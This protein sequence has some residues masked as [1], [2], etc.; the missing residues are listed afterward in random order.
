MKTRTI[1]FSF[2]L[3]VPALLMAQPP[4]VIDAYNLNQAIFGKD[5]EKLKSMIEAGSDVNF[6]YNGR[7]ALHTACDKGSL[8]MAELLLKNGAIPDFALNPDWSPLFEAI[9]NAHMES[10]KVLL[11]H[12]AKMDLKNSMDQTLRYMWIT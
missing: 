10:V 8:E 7:N 12:G 9:T 11:E 5:V 4:E 2:L 3:L 6:Q 1:A